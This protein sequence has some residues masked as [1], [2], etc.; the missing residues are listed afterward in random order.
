MRK[1]RVARLTVRLRRSRNKA[2]RER[3]L[4]QTLAERQQS[5]GSSI[6]GHNDNADY[7][8]AARLAAGN[9]PARRQPRRP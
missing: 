3:V 4:S 6:L 8:K 7:C 2:E 1:V 9:F 5:L